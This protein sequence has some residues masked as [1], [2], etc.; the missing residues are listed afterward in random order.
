M[1]DKFKCPRC[2]KEVES[3][4]VALSRKDNET[5]ICSDCGEKEA[6]ENYEAT[7]DQM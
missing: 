3:W 7:K 2:G 4:S 6:M 1:N 5:E